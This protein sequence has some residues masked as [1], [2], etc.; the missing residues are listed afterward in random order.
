MSSLGNDFDPVSRVVVPWIFSESRAGILPKAA[1]LPVV[2][3]PLP[4]GSLHEGFV[5]DAILLILV[6]SGK[7][8]FACIF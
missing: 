1:D 2:L 8:H 4:F 6:I 3:G 5:S 7:S